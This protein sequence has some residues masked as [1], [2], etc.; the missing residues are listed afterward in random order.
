M[1]SSEAMLT[2][3]LGSQHPYVYGIVQRDWNSESQANI[4]GINTR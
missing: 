1:D 4:N 2:V 3:T